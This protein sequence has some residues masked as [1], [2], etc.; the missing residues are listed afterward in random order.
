MTAAT[1]GLASNSSRCL[2]RMPPGLNRAL[3]I[4]HVTLTRRSITPARVGDSGNGMGE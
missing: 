3:S 1:S 2:I 4:D